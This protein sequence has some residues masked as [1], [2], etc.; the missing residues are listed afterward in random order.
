MASETGCSIDFRHPWIRR[1]FQGRLPCNV[2]CGAAVAG[3]A[4]DAGLHICGLVLL[5]LR[6]EIRLWISRVAVD[7]GAVPA[8]ERSRPVVGAA[9]LCGTA[10]TKP[11]PIMLIRVP[12]DVECL[13]PSAT[14]I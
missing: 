3:L 9:G 12:G 11:E 2:F 7:A 1:G 10:F 13:Q 14:D 6:L 8:I 4:T 5:C